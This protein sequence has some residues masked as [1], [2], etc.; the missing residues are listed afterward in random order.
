MPLSVIKQNSTYLCEIYICTK[1]EKDSVNFS[2]RG[3]FRK[4]VT[5][6]QEIC[7]NFKDNPDNENSLRT[8][9]LSPTK[10]EKESG[11]KGE[12][13]VEFKREKFDIKISFGGAYAL[14]ITC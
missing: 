4:N 6:P 7:V 5:F 13:D 8:I 11:Q 14:R 10:R 12:R 2:L 9:E 3:I 1:H